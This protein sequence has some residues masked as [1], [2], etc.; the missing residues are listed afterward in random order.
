MVALRRVHIIIHL[1]IAVPILW[2]V[3]NWHNFG[4]F[5]WLVRCCTGR[6]IDVLEEKGFILLENPIHVINN[7][8]IMGYF[9]IFLQEFPP[10]PN[11][12]NVCAEAKINIVQ[13]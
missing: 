2:S 1:S 9:D 12:L 13:L 10:L 11:A 5:G 6:I 4:Q 7:Y 8:F 3:E